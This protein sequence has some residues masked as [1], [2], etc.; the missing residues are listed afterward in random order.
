MSRTWWAD[1]SRRLATCILACAALGACSSDAGVSGTTSDGRGGSTD[2]IDVGDRPI[3][4]DA[5]EADGRPVRPDRDVDRPETTPEDTAVLDVGPDLG[6]A[7]DTSIDDA[8]V[9]P[10]PDTGA[11]DVAVDPLDVD[12]ADV[13]ADSDADAETGSG[14]TSRLSGD[15]ECFHYD[16][17]LANRSF[18][19]KVDDIAM[20]YTVRNTCARPLTFRVRRE[21]DF[22]PIVIEQDGEPWVYLPDCPAPDGTAPGEAR[23]FEFRAGEGWSRGRFWNASEHEAQLERCGVTF[24][25]AASY[26]VRGYGMVETNLLEPTDFSSAFP[27]TE[28]IPI[29]LRP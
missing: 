25:P 2:R 5:D 18:D 4:V 20:T 1:A 14:T 10:T 19:F 11:E 15:Y 27:I 22:F 28:A 29:E 13:A 24:D 26:A 17:Y 21:N 16:I 7:I 23:E 9:R 3:D 8:F 12:P 6:V